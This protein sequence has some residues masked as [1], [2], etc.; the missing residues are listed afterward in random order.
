M[1]KTKSSI[2]LVTLLCSGLLACSHQPV[3]HDGENVALRDKDGRWKCSSDEL[4]DSRL[5][6][7]QPSKHPSETGAVCYYP[8][9]MA[10]YYAKSRRA[11]ASDD[12][13]GLLD[14]EA[15]RVLNCVDGIYQKIRTEGLSVTAA[16]QEAKKCIEDVAQNDE[17][18]RIAAWAQATG[19]FNELLQA[20]MA[21]IADHMPVLKDHGLKMDDKG[22]LDFRD[23]DFRSIQNA[24]VVAAMEGV[25]GP[26]RSEHG[27]VQS[28]KSIYFPTENS[29]R[30]TAVQ[31]GGS[32]VAPNL[33]TTKINGRN[34]PVVLSVPEYTNLLTSDYQKV[35][36]NLQL[37]AELSAQTKGYKNI[38]NK[39]FRSVFLNSNHQVSGRE[40]E[41]DAA[42]NDVI[43]GFTDLGRKYGLETSQIN[44]FLRQL[45]DMVSKDTKNIN[46]LLTYVEVVDFAVAG[47][48]TGGM[49]AYF[50][51]PVAVAA[52]TVEGASLAA[53]GAAVETAAVAGTGAAA[54]TGL[55]AW[56][57]GSI[58]SNT[59]LAGMGFTAG[60]TGIYSAFKAAGAARNGGGGFWCNFAQNLLLDETGAFGAY[61][62]LGGPLAAVLGI[63]I[64]KYL[65]KA[66]KASAPG[67]QWLAQLFNRS[68]TTAGAEQIAS[69]TFG[70]GVAGAFLG[71]S[72]V[73]ESKAA[74]Q[75]KIRYDQLMA[76]GRTKEAEIVR[77]SRAVKIWGMVGNAVAFVPL[78]TVVH[79]MFGVKPRL[80]PHEVGTSAKPEVRVV[81]PKGKIAERGK[82]EGRTEM[83]A[84]ETSTKTVKTTV[85]EVLTSA[86]VAPEKVTTKQQKAL[87]E[88]EL[89]TKPVEGKKGK[90][91]PTTEEV[92]VLATRARNV[93]S[94]FGVKFHEVKSGNG[95]FSIFVIEGEGTAMPNVLKRS[96]DTLAAKGEGYEV[97][98]TADP[99]L[100]V[101][102]NPEHIGVSETVTK[103]GTDGKPSVLTRIWL[104]TKALANPRR[105]KEVVNRMCRLCGGK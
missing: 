70:F 60:A 34:G 20:H 82:I 23:F 58:V 38:V 68:V 53:G 39:W 84:T 50:A 48:A 54:G 90:S 72:T 77:R 105:L 74:K 21:D 55:V 104:S 87:E 102:S 79:S 47:V 42:Y 67:V 69:V 37:F 1:H 18:M 44:G 98:Y 15:T 11:P 43:R 36:N 99:T 41:K 6:N 65:P 32:V 95:E 2:L 94:E 35:R 30:P 76:Q 8:P 73:H 75:D 80:A 88:L 31:L 61:Y 22:N 86:K 26:D 91:K 24:E 92:N 66:A 89:A 28:L 12:C 56:F 71:P 96:L 59:A 81:E 93:L 64:G 52:V 5:L 10:E 51:A 13:T 46:E 103:V 40:V 19:R 16:D 4:K 49:I 17:K 83:P 100:N 97:L 9:D 101:A 63:G 14:E 33:G 85:D 29:G 27:I 25:F 45:M 78:G 7:T 62:G 57:T 3:S